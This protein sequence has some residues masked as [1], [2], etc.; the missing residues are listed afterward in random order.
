MFWWQTRGWNAMW[1]IVLIHAQVSIKLFRVDLAWRL[2]Y[3]VT[4][5]IGRD[6]RVSV[7]LVF[8]W[9]GYS[10][11]WCAEFMAEA[12]WKLYDTRSRSWREGKTC[13]KEEWGQVSYLSTKCLR[14][15]SSPNSI[16]VQVVSSCLSSNPECEEVDAFRP[17]RSEAQLAVKIPTTGYRVKVQAIRAETSEQYEEQW[18]PESSENSRACP[19]TVAPI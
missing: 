11:S 10:S 13:P 9:S 18:P 6:W 4:K 12:G 1:K 17:A 7:S 16:R 15:H 5:T 8:R 3:I 2:S 14:C 19:S